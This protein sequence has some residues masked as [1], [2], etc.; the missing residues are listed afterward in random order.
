[1]SHKSSTRI[2]LNLWVIKSLKNIL[3]NL[4][5]TKKWWTTT[6]SNNKEGHHQLTPKWR[7]Y[8]L[9]MRKESLLDQLTSKCHKQRPHKWVLKKSFWPNPLKKKVINSKVMT[10]R[11]FSRSKVITIKW[12]RR[13]STFKMSR[14]TI[15]KRKLFM[16]RRFNKCKSNRIRLW[17]MVLVSSQMPRPIIVRQPLVSFHPLVVSD[18]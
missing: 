18:H 16:I 3:I 2:A 7:L 8:Q 1:M 5:W 6:H 13:S 11:V 4:H 14:I 9:I 12:R 10:N 17:A 15:S